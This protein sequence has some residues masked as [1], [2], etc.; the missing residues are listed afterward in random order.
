M[1]RGWC[2]GG[3]GERGRVG[4]GR[5]TGALR[6]LRFVY[7]LLLAAVSRWELDIRGN[8]RQRVYENHLASNR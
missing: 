1:V 4:K 5:R 8:Q 7:F 6:P 2:W 3:K